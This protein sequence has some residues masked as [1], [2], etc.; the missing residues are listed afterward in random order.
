MTPKYVC[1]LGHKVYYALELKASY[2]PELAEAPMLRHESPDTTAK[3]LGLVKE[4]LKR[5][6]DRAVAEIPGD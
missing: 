1:Q 4:D 5:T 2:Q 6:C 3:Y